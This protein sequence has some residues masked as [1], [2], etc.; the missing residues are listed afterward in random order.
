MWEM[1]G[2]ARDM[3]PVQTEDAEHGKDFALFLSQNTFVLKSA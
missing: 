3:L 1:D 2:A